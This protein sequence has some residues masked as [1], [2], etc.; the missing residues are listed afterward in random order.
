MSLPRF[1]LVIYRAI[2]LSWYL[3]FHL[4]NPRLLTGIL[5]IILKNFILSSAL[6][7]IASRFNYRY[8]ASTYLLFWV[9]LEEIPN[10]LSRSS[11]KCIHVWPRV[12]SPL[13]DILFNRS[14]GL[15]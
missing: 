10:H 9:G 11:W 7:K 6:L 8:S 13:Y 1:H 4:F 2:S 5:C 12:T 3:L 14:T 15:A